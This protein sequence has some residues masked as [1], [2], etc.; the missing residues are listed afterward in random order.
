M[1][2]N[3][4][5]KKIAYFDSQVNAVWSSMVYGEDEQKKLERL[6]SH[7][8]SF[9]G[10]TVLEPG[11]GTGR[12]TEVLSNQVGSEGKVVAMD[13]SP[14]MIEAAKARLNNRQ[15]IE[16]HAAAV[17]DFPLQR[18]T[19]DLILCHQVFP[20]FEDKAKVLNILAG[21]LKPGHRLIVI[22]FI[23]FEEIND[24][25]RKAGTAVEHDMMPPSKEMERLF[26]EAGLTIEF[27]RNDEL[28]YFLSSHK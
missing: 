9:E 12:L 20:H 1:K 18:E 25:H 2:V 27:L 19:F 14:K 5:Q 21:A 7:V 16:I 26:R 10:M 28:G 17:E 4:Y 22:H 6:F 24:L 11:C 13:I 15:N 8:G 3:G 23:N